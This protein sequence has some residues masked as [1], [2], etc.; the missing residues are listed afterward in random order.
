[1]ARY[2]EA[3]QRGLKTLRRQGRLRHLPHRPG[4]HQRRIPRHRHR[5]LRAPWRVDP[6]RHGGIKKLLGDRMNLLGPLQRRPEARDRRRHAAR[7]AR[8]P[9]LRRIQSAV[10]AQPR[11]EH[12]LHAQRQPRHPARRREAL[13][14]DQPRP[15]ALR[16]ARAILKPLHLTDGETA[17]L[18]A[19]LQTLSD[20]GGQYQR[21]PFPE[22]LPLGIS[23]PTSV[24][25]QENPD[26]ESRGSTQR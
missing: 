21:R 20:R 18:V 2:P 11:I 1:M 22:E 12:A 15:A 23:A 13:L 6:G 7:L 5:L 8:A 26:S 17:D 4:V 3:A 14:R 16:T 25:C 9:Q 10:A 24:R 19:F